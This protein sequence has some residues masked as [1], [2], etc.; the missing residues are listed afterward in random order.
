MPVAVV[1]DRMT[2]QR[3]SKAAAEIAQRKAKDQHR[4][5]S[6]KPAA[7]L[8][9]ALKQARSAIIAEALECPGTCVLH[10]ITWCHVLTSSFLSRL[11]ST[12]THWDDDNPD[13]R[14][15]F[16]P[17]GGGSICCDPGSE[18]GR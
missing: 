7:T 16:D 9:K 11:H 14:S 13:D 12:R 3:V 1:A 5:V 15:K 17:D 18:A 10:I 4:N 6:A 2:I 8:E